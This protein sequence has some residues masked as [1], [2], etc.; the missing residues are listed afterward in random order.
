MQSTN[1]KHDTSEE[2]SAPTTAATHETY[3]V[4]VR[5]ERFSNRD[6]FV[7]RDASKTWRAYGDYLNIAMTPQEI[8]EYLFHREEIAAAGIDNGV[9]FVDLFIFPLRLKA[10]EQV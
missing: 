6:S 8:A 4:T 2:Y 10:S 3:R 1:L 9:L 5:R 7:A